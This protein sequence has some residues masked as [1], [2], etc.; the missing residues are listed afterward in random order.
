MDKFK[1]GDM[2]LSP[3]KIGCR[4]TIEKIENGIATLKGYDET[5]QVEKLEKTYP[6]DYRVYPNHPMD[7]FD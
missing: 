3:N 7:M 4:T 2:V 1:V 6:G 5:F